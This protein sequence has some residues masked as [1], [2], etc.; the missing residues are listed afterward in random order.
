MVRCTVEVKTFL[1]SCTRLNAHVYSDNYLCVV[2]IHFVCPVKEEKNRLSHSAL[3]V[4]C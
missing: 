1:P 4:C 3:Q 2:V